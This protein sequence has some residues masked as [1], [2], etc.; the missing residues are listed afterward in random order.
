MH[1]T[2]IKSLTAES[3]A[4]HLTTRD[5]QAD[6]LYAMINR[7]FTRS[8]ARL[9]EVDALGYTRP[10]LFELWETTRELE[11]VADHAEGIAK[12]APAID[13]TVPLAVLDEIQLF[14]REARSLVA[15]GVSVIVGDAG[16]ETAHET[17][18]ARDELCKQ[19]K[20]YAD[21]GGATTESPQVRP[22]LHRIQRTAEHGGNIAEL[23]L[24][25]AVR[26]KEL[27]VP[28]TV[29]ENVS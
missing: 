6:R 10:E 28:Q 20:T 25:H 5:D 18:F 22:V 8:L 7:S 27:T 2:A 3:A 16:A 29:D 12:T 15:D 13:D 23:G 11:R 24:Q 14:G 4:A 17:L 26:H 21:T 1:E 19:I 9:D